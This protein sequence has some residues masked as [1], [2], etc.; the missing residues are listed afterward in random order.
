MLGG[1]ER[2]AD[3]GQFAKLASPDAGAVHH[4][5]R[6]DIAVRRP[7]GGHGAMLARETGDRDAFD[8]RHTAHPS[9]LG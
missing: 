2:D 9:A 1:L 6:F 8:D 4:V 7:H 3:T 5:L